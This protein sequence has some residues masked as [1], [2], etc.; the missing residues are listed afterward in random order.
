MFSP[1]ILGI[2]VISVF[3]RTGGKSKI[4]SLHTSAAP[5]FCSGSYGKTSS[6]FP[7]ITVWTNTHSSTSLCKRLLL[8]LKRTFCS[9]RFVTSHSFVS[10]RYSHCFV[11]AA[12]LHIL[13][14]CV[15]WCRFSN[16]F[17]YY[18]VVLLTTE[19]FQEG[20]VCGSEW[21]LLCV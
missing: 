9:L 21:K 19:L 10:L 18:G 8:K 16:A 3:R 5:L 11:L 4:F 1:L 20:G 7:L 2:T 14:L 15:F 12:F 6:K 13:Y 17:S